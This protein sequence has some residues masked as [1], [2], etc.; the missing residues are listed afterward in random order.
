M[1]VKQIMMMTVPCGE[2][3]N[4]VLF[5]QDLKVSEFVVHPQFYSGGLYN[6]IAL[7]FLQSS[8]ILAPHIDTVCLPRSTPLYDPSACFATGWGK[9]AFGK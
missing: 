8:A 5:F 3:E 6:D 2:N 1:V 4:P 9:N 7:V